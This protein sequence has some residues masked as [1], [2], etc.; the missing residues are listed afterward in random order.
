MTTQTPGAIERDI[1][2]R[3]HALFPDETFEHTNCRA[4][5]PGPLKRGIVPSRFKHVFYREDLSQDIYGWGTKVRKETSAVLANLVSSELDDKRGWHTPML[6][7]DLPARLIESSSP[8]HYHLYIDKPMPWW[9]YKRLMRALMMAGIIE[10]NYYKMS[11]KRKGS[12]LRPPWVDKE[13]R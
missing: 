5:G 6:D 2:E 9:K 13:T 3:E 11:V 10:K 4:C 8:G 1:Q 12:H 7:I